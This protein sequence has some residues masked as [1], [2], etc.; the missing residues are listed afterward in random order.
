MK[1]DFLFNNSVFVDVTFEMKFFVCSV[2]IG[3]IEE[4]C[5]VFLKWLKT[6]CN[7]ILFHSYNLYLGCVTKSFV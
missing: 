6:K 1:A 7:D 5:L 2:A 3:V 4:V